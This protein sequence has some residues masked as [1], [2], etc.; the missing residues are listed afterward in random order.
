MGHPSVY[1]TGVTIYNPDKCWSGYTILPIKEVGIVV[2]D[3]N[4]HEVRVFKDM[5][6]FPAK[7]WPGGHVLGSRGLRSGKYGMQDQWDLVQL[8]WDGNV[9]WEFD[10]VEFIEDPGQEPRWM[11][12]QHHDYQREGNPVGYYAPNMEPK[13]DSGN[14]L[15]LSHRNVIN[16]KIS[17]KAL[18]DD[19]I[20]EVDWE[21][22]IVWEWLCSDHFD[23]FGFRE[24]AKNALSRNPNYR[25]VGKGMGDWM[26]INSMSALGPNKWYDQGDE[27]FH[28][29]NII[30][31]GRET[32]I[33]FIISKKPAKLFGNS[34]QTTTVPPKKEPLAGLS[35]NTIAT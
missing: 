26:H 6:G 7:L 17:D 5:H 14:T 8:D 16:K 13:I 2:I 15:V 22:N 12:R 34:A 32:N 33:N 35:G 31:D 25:P 23:E 1:P 9:V 3:M 10:R 18:L 28:P 4:G 24:A 27:R 20:V 11:A 21:G 30:C 19:L 29:D